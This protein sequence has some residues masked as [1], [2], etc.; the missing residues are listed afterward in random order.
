MGLV[1]FAQ[2][3]MDVYDTTDEDGGGSE[4]EYAS[5]QSRVETRWVVVRCG[6]SLL[7]QPCSH[8]N[9]FDLEKNYWTVLPDMKFVLYLCLYF[10][11]CIYLCVCVRMGI[12]VCL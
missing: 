11:I 5:V 4:L 12:S 10:Y 9:L 3:E 8:A 1:P 6:G 2:D 7:K